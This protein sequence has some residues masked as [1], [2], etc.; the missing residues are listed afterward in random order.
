MIRGGWGGGSPQFHR[1]ATT[2]IEDVNG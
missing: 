1:G 2:I